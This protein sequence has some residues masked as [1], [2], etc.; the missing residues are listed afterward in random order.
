MILEVFLPNI[1]YESK[2]IYFLSS[3]SVKILKS[4]CSHNNGG[5]W[6][7]TKWGSAPNRLCE[8]PSKYIYGQVR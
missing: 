4:Y 1:F 3:L 5:F 8:W 7:I 6:A 2:N